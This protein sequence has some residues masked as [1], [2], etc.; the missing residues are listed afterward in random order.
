MTFTP[1]SPLNDGDEPTGEEGLKEIIEERDKELKDLYD[2]AVYKDS[3]FKQ[4]QEDRTQEEFDKANKGIN[5]LYEATKVAAD[6]KFP[7]LGELFDRI[8]TA[9]DGKPRTNTFLED[10]KLLP[11]DDTK[12]ILPEGDETNFLSRIYSTGRSGTINLAIL[13]NLQAMISR[14][15][16]TTRKKNPSPTKLRE[17]LGLNQGDKPV[18]GS[19]IKDFVDN[20]ANQIEE[21]SSKYETFTYG[22]MNEVIE[23]T[24]TEDDLTSEEKVNYASANADE[25]DLS[26]YLDQLGAST[27]SRKALQIKFVQPFQKKYGATD[28]QVKRYVRLTNRKVGNLK[29]TLLYLNNFYKGTL[30]TNDIDEIAAD[31]SL[32]F[33]QDIKPET[34][35]AIIKGQGGEILFQTDGMKKRKQAPFSIKTREDLLKVYQSRID[36]LNKH[37]AF[38]AGH[39]YAADQLLKDNNVSSASMYDN[40]EPEIR[41]TIRRLVSKPELEQLINGQLTKG[42]DYIDVIIGNRSKKAGGDPSDKVFEELYGNSYGLEEDFRK[43]LFPDEDIANMIIPDLKPRFGRQYTAKVKEILERFKGTEAKPGFKA[44]PGLKVGSASLTKIRRDAVKEILADYVEGKK[45]TQKDI[46]YQKSLAEMVNMFDLLLQREMVNPKTGT[47]YRGNEPSGGG[48]KLTLDDV[49]TER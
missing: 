4:I 34:I 31:M 20:I 16:T 33:N 12:G 15:L 10:Q 25:I 22:D 35:D 42:T 40:L 18:Q 26:T 43:F 48:Y 47:V 17:L 41:A 13:E 5:T 11:T 3:E 21:D 38:D 36:L 46:E 44:T 9:F 29:K 32:V 14:T 23:Q 8:K 39:V 28:E 27:I 49:L 24:L 6:I 1:G 30:P 45:V 7:G 37:G 2:E 19:L